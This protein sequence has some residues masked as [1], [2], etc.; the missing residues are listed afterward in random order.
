MK[1][2][3]SEEKK[4][5]SLGVMQQLSEFLMSF[6]ILSK[7]RTSTATVSEADYLNNRQFI[8]LKLVQ[9]FPGQV[10]EKTLGLVLDILFS[11]SGAIVD[12]LVGIQALAPK[13]GRGKPLALGKRARLVIDKNQGYQISRLAQLCSDLSPE[14]LGV[15]LEIS[16]RLMSNTDKIIRTELLGEPL[17]IET[18]LKRV[19]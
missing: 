1:E 11:Q 4:V 6:E 9:K 5:E 19:L 8:T 16:Q 12:H 3:N 2:L 17:P 13:A 7:Y 18:V 14:E 10:T 15:I